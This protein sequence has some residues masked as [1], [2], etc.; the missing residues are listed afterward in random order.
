MSTDSSN[1]NVTKQFVELDIDLDSSLN[2]FEDSLSPAQRKRA[3]GKKKATKKS[4]TQKLKEKEENRRREI[5]DVLTRG[6]VE[7]LKE[8][9]ENVVNVAETEDAKKEKADEFINEAIEPEGMNTLLHLA[10][11]NEHGGLVEFLLANNANPTL[12][13]KSQQTGYSCTQSK[14]IR[15]IFKQFAK[16]NPEKYNYNKV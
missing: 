4:R 15:E 9:L 11:M 10:A 12:K 14:E 16:D 5:V 8:L 13:N 6:D 3:P 2:E 7:K 1:E